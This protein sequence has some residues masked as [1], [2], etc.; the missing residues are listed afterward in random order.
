M[1]DKPVV[2]GGKLK[3]KGSGNNKTKVVN[4]STETSTSSSL[5]KRSL[6]ASSSTTT[7]TTTTEASSTTSSSSSGN[8]K[9]DKEDVHLTEAQ[10]R[11][12]AK[13]AEIESKRAR[14][15]AKTSFRDRVEDFNM[16]LSK[17]TEHNDIPRVSAAGNG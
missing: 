10:K 1:S 11:F 15:L 17:M 2:I 6:D 4:S 8:S 12:K 7:N 5:G 14:E 3:L 13:R 9:E 16:R